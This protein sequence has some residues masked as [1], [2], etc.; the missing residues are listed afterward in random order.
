ME[1]FTEDIEPVEVIGPAIRQ[2]AN[3]M[4]FEMYN[5]QELVQD[6]NKVKELRRLSRDIVIDILH[7]QKDATIEFPEIKTYQ[8]YLY[9]HSVNVSVLSVLLGFKLGLG[10]ASLEDLALGALLHDIGK[11]EIPL[12]ILDKQ[13]SLNEAEYEVIKEHPRNGFNILRNSLYIKPRSFTVALQHHETCDGSGYPSGRKGEEIHIFSRIAVVADIFDA[14]TTDRP[15]KQRWSFE[16]TISYLLDITKKLDSKVLD[17]FLKVFPM[18]PLGTVVILSNNET[19]IVFAQNKQDLRK[20][21][22]R[23]IKDAKGREIPK[24]NTYEINLREHA[25][26][27]IVSS[28]IA[29]KAK[30]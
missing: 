30:G 7:M 2:Q 12:S 16:K 6:N 3:S 11:V 1:E 24:E 20:P 17:E 15:Y 14:L 22:V 19:G 29:G 10:D 28:V 13:S 27:K 5:D 4:V 26:I 21:Q 18:Y 8:N 25:D 23:I 9:L